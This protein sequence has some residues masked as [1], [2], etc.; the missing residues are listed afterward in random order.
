MIDITINR[1]SS[2]MNSLYKA[3]INDASDDQ[4]SKDIPKDRLM[5]SVNKILPEKMKMCDATF[6][7]IVELQ[8]KPGEQVSVD[9]FISIGFANLSTQKLLTDA[10]VQRFSEEGRAAIG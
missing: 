8:F 4:G 1:H 2:A 7:R 5:T 9:F 6:N 10:I 3:I